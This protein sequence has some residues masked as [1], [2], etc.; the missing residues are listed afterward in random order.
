MTKKAVRKKKTS[1][2]GRITPQHFFRFLTCPYWVYYEQ[3]GKP[4]ER[5]EISPLM[6]KIMEDAVLHEKEKLSKF[7][8]EEVKEK[9][10]EEGFLKTLALMR[11]GK[12]VYQGVL[13]DG[14]WVGKPDYLER[15]EGKESVFGDYYYVAMDIKS[16]RELRDEHKMQ[17]IFY[18]L[19]LEKIQGVRSETGVMI[20]GDGDF[21]EFSIDEE[22]EKFH[23]TLASIEK[24]LGGEKPPHFFSSSCKESPWYGVCKK[25]S[26]ACD[27]VSLIPRL[28]R[29]DWKLFLERG[30]KTIHDVADSD[31]ETLRLKFPEMTLERLERVHT[32]ARSLAK[33][34]AIV[35]EAPH[36]PA[37]SEEL[38]FDIE[39][40]PLRGREYLFGILEVHG[41]TVQYVSFL[42]ETPDEAG[43]K[44]M[45]GEFMDYMAKHK[46]AAIY[47]Y[48]TYE[49]TVLDR[50]AERYGADLDLLGQIHSNR[51]NLLS[52]VARCV[53]LPVYFYSLKDVAKG[54]GFKWHR[55][56]ASGANSIVWYDEW[57]R[58]GNRELLDRIV[59]YNEDDVRATYHVK[60]WLEG[61]AR[62]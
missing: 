48:G 12:N 1:A 37:A 39:G 62:A 25:E 2:A 28:R 44:K 58:T 4:E 36:F 42:A 8:F 3:H 26:I 41:R 5:G 22:L 21:M 10:L 45:W 30:V 53:A 11:K 57:L 33:Q 24:I 52:V 43:E 60:K 31:I 59:Q 56:D 54:F 13:I 9:D 34:E 18:N 15:R 50:F 47:H 20:N 51:V 7:K 23:L 46:D 6:M 40:D 29:A 27:D 49:A 61:L 14:T 38:Y 35:L 16:G 55:E 19:L 32:Q 17:I